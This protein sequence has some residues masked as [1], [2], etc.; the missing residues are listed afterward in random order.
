MVVVRLHSVILALHCVWESRLPRQHHPAAT[1]RL[2]IFASSP[3]FVCLRLC[4]CLCLH[5]SSARREESLDSLI[6][7]PD[8]YKSGGL[9][10]PR[11]RNLFENR[12]ILARPSS[13]IKCRE[14]VRGSSTNKKK[15]KA[16][17]CL[18]IGLFMGVRILQRLSRLLIE[19]G[20]SI[21]R[22]HIEFSLA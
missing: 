19:T 5:S 10:T 11:P 4:V 22:L 3:P 20:Y 18:F 2:W 14:K 13:P 12:D 15:K 8:P 7:I 17:P 21:S 9:Y 1:F 6:Q 16:L